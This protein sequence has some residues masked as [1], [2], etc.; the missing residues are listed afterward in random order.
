MT[1]Q[2]PNLLPVLPEIVLVVGAMLLL[3]FGAYRGE[4]ES[5]CE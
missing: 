1:T 4:R 5:D 2:L 3:M